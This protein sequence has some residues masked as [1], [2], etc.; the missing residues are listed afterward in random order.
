MD[1]T[2]GCSLYFC[3]NHSPYRLILLSRILLVTKLRKN[4]PKRQINCENV[5]DSKV[6]YSMMR[7]DLIE[8]DNV[9]K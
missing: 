7:L 2:G 9:E 1:I 8:H 6:R 4:R 3:C 5:R